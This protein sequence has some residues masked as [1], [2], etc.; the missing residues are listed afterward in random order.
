MRRLLGS[1][2]LGALLIAGCSGD[3]ADGASFDLRE[4]A[5]TGPET[6]VEGPQSVAVANSGAFPHTLV[7]TDS[8][9]QVVTATGLIAPGES[10][11]V[12]LDLPAG[13]YSL[14]C[15]IVAQN[16]EGELIDHFEAG[17]HTTLTVDD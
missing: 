6:I 5:I 2:V 11:S 12:D 16:D 17:M 15:R 10:I 13:R 8:T 9:G 3:S 14:T 7:V 1:V 4:F